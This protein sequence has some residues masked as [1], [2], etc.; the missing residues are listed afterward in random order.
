MSYQGSE[1]DRVKVTDIYREQYAHFR[2]MNDILYKIPPI[3]T[4]IIGALW[5]FAASYICKDKTVSAAVFVFS[6]PLAF[7]SS[8]YCC[9]LDGHFPA[10]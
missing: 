3:M 8:S 1:D 7:A 5:Y 10:T 9:D 4:T 6:V 2:A